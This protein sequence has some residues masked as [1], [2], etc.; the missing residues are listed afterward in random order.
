MT[1]V[2]IR[3]VFVL[4]LDDTQEIYRHCTGG[5]VNTLPRPCLYVVNIEPVRPCCPYARMTESITSITIPLEIYKRLI[6]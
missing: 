6:R 3:I 2:T 1:S 4:I 5:D